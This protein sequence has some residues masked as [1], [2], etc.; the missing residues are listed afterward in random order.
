MTR[1]LSSFRARRRHRSQQS[2]ATAQ[3]RH[4]LSNFT[5]ESARSE[6]ATM[7]G[8]YPAETTEELRGIL[9]TTR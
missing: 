2:A 5:T 1:M 6:L 7:I 9:E 3:L 4:E 8:R